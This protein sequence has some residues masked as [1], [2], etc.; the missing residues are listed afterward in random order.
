[1]VGLSPAG[2][3][4]VA[5]LAARRAKSTS[6]V[7]TNGETRRIYQQARERDPPLSR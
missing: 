7:T 2:V 4:I 5:V 6:Y 1:M 3:S